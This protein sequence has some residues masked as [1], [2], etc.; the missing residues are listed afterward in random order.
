M[1]LSKVLKALVLIGAVYGFLL[2][3]NLLGSGLKLWGRGFTTQLISTTSN[4]F[5][6]LFIGILTT[7]L[8]QSS[9][10]TTCIVVAFVG[11]GALSVSNA[12]PIIMGANIGTTVTNTLVSL[13]HITRREEFGRAFSAAVVHDFF[14]ILSVLVFFPL[15][16]YFHIIEKTSYFLAGTFKGI[17]GLKITSPLKIILDPASRS[18]ESLLTYKPFIIVPFSLVFLFISLTALVVMSRSLM[19][20]KAELFLDK[21]LFGTSRN[22]FFL[23]LLLTAIIQSSS[24]TTSL[25]VPLV[26]TGLLSLRKIYPYVLGANIGTVV[27]AILAAWVT[28]SFVGA[29]AAFAHLSFNILGILVWYPLRRVPLGLAEGFSSLVKGKRTLAFVYMIL[30]FFAVPLFLIILTRR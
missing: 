14:N 20:G 12:I 24:V 15:E 13:S 26:G 22:S 27:T 2:S 3:I 1:R 6:G 18:I 10:C 29:Q 9:S 4:P 17:G 11:T 25:A 28:G 16:I 30:G 8:V 7:S 21:Y 19:S 5:V 23:G